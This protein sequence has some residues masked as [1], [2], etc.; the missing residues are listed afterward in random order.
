MRPILA[1]QCDLCREGHV[2]CSVAGRVVLLI[3][4]CRAW[5]GLRLIC[6]PILKS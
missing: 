1:L 6:M 2:G 5:A 4:V 3:T